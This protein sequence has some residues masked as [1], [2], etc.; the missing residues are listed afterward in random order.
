M[1]PV[2]RRILHS[3][4]PNGTRAVK[5]LDPVRRDPAVQ[6]FPHV[7]IRHRVCLIHKVNQPALIHLPPLE[8]QALQLRSR[9]RFHPAQLFGPCL[10]ARTVTLA[11]HPIN[12]RQIP[13][14]RFEIP[15]TANRQRQ[16]HMLTEMT[17]AHLHTP[18]LVRPADIDRPRFQP[19]VIQHTHKP[20]IEHSVRTFPPRQRRT[21]IQLNT[22]RQPEPKRKPMH[23]HL[24][25]LKALPPTHTH[26]LH[27]RK[28]KHTMADL[29]LKHLPANRNPHPAHIRPVHLHPLPRP[30][31]LREKQLLRLRPRPLTP[32]PPLQRP[33][34]AVRELPFM[35]QLKPPQRIRPPNARRLFEQPIQLPVH[36]G[37]RI[38]PRPMRPRPFH[39]R[40]QHP[41]L[42]PLRPR[43]PAHI[44]PQRSHPDTPC[45][46]KL[47]KEP[48]HLPIRLQLYR[49]RPSFRRIASITSATSS[50]VA[51]RSAS[52]AR[53]GVGPS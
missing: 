21:V 35:L 12:E 46:G 19:I 18:V 23:E 17:V 3:N 52:T 36:L 48:T 39:I 9:H 24:Q 5:H 42:Q 50:F 45:P 15:A 31:L 8:P 41:R 27:L 49:L 1:T 38:R 37:K 26:M 4:S 6:P 34:P 20:P 16:F 47:L 14:L 30:P 44:R 53:S 13:R 32:H 51:A 22:R 7:G 43:L 28:R 40:G 10:P 11:E 29:M 25:R 33:Q 2:D